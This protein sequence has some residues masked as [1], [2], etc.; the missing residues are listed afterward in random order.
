MDN[1]RKKVRC[2]FVCLAKFSPLYFLLLGQL[3]LQV[4]KCKKFFLPEKILQHLQNVSQ[5]NNLKEMCLCII[6][7]QTCMYKKLVSKY[8]VFCKFQK[9]KKKFC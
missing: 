9:V 4:S 8:N 7:Y 6:E 2:L 5:Q 3:S 1:T